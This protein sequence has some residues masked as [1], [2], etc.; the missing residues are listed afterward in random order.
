M[1]F[2]KKLRD[3][4]EIYSYRGAFVT[5]AG[6]EWLDVN[7]NGEP[8][9]API[10]FD[11]RGEPVAWDDNLGNVYILDNLGNIIPEVE[12]PI[13]ES[14]APRNNFSRAS[15]ASA[16]GTKARSQKKYADV[17]PTVATPKPKSSYTRNPTPVAESRST[18]T[19]R[20]STN[21]SSNNQIRDLVTY[22][23]ANGSELLPLV[24][25]TKTTV[26]VVVD[27]TKK[28]YKF[29]EIDNG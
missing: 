28:T 15:V 10:E 12:E 16:G 7:E 24:D 11:R 25:D 26:K 14:R 22:T 1:Q 5:Q 2:V 13:Y 23:P 29:E 4:T 8:L 9:L 18:R 21:V 3:G 20:A 17:K 19:E 6:N 27:D